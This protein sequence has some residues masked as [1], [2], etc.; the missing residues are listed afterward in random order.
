MTVEYPAPDRDD[1]IRLRKEGLNREDI[2]LRFGVSL[3][4]VK[5]WIKEMGIPAAIN[6]RAAKK[7]VPMDSAE[8]GED[9]GLTLIE[10]A[11]KT[12]GTRMT[13]DYRGYLLD[14]RL[15][16]IDILLQAAGLKVRA[17]P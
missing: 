16:R 11:K 5:R 6:N 2:A 4:R 7:I 17:I 1:L 8:L 13:Q 12:L 14:G 3:A 15:V 9:Y 10:K